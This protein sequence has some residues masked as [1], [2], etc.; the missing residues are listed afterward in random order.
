MCYRPKQRNGHGNVPDCVHR[1]GQHGPLIRRLRSRA[2]GRRDVSTVT[3]LRV[4]GRYMTGARR[5]A[6]PVGGATRSR[7]PARQ[8]VLPG[9]GQIWAAETT[10]ANGSE[11]A[12]HANAEPVALSAVPCRSYQPMGTAASQSFQNWLQNGAASA[13]K[14]LTTSARALADVFRALP[15]RR[16][17]PRG[18]PGGLQVRRGGG[19][20]RPCDH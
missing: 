4:E 16:W 11:G 12:K 1:L 7:A 18:R 19:Q 13:P 9:R 8:R 3:H 20:C 2:G 15:G 6:S 14:R 17:A 5:G 10:T